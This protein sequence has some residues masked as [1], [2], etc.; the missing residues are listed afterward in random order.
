MQRAVGHQD[1]SQLRT[2]PVTFDVRVPLYY[3]HNS[4]KTTMAPLETKGHPNFASGHEITSILATNNGLYAA[5]NGAVFRLD[6]NGIVT[7]SINLPGTGHND[8][9]LAASDDCS[10]LIAGTNGYVVGLNVQSLQAQ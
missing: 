6:G 7:A 5:K 1:M 3:I 9:R 10:L 2:Y 4:T 8:I